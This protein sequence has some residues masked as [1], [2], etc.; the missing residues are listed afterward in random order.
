M[1]YYEHGHIKP[2]EAITAFPAQ[3]IKAAFRHMQPGKHIGKIVVTMPE[4]YD[5]ISATWLDHGNLKFSR[6]ST[7]LLAGGLGG[8]GKAL[9]SWMVEKGARNLVFLSRSAGKSSEDAQ[10]L[11]E[12]R[13]QGCQAVPVCGNVADTDDVMKA[14]NHAPAPVAG[15]FQLSMVLKVSRYLTCSK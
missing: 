11:E 6:S 1:A 4:N 12:L 7:Y 10:F 14:I 13:S 9:A 2:I 15:V 5:D 3:D 8:L